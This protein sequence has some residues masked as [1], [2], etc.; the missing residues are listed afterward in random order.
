M[1]A[2]AEYNCGQVRKLQYIIKP[3]AHL[4]IKLFIAPMH[5]LFLGGDGDSQHQRGCAQHSN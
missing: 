1:G 5:F 2:C 4:S 3:A